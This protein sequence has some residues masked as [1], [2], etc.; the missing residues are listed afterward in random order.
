MQ[1]LIISIFPEGGG[2]GEDGVLRRQINTCRKVPL[3]VN[4]FA[5]PSMSLI[6]LRQENY[7]LIVIFSVSQRVFANRFKD[8]DNVLMRFSATVVYC[9]ITDGVYPHCRLQCSSL[10]PC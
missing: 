8:R 7:L 9:E 6:S 1:R 5:L 10:T 3:K 4:F 2:W